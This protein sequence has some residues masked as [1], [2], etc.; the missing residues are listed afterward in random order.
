MIP[1]LIDQLPLPP[2]C[3]ELPENVYRMS[4]PVDLMLR[5]GRL[6]KGYLLAFSAK[7]ARVLLHTDA[8]TPTDARYVLFKDIALLTVPQA[9][10]VVRAS[11]ALANRGK[12]VVPPAKQEFEVYVRGGS[13]IEGK[14]FSFRMDRHGLYLFPAKGADNFSLL[15]AAYEA[16]EK[17]RIGPLLGKALISDKAATAAVIDAGLAEQKRKREQ[18]LG[19]YLQAALVVSAEQLNEVLKRQ[20]S[21]PGVRLGEMLLRENMVSE[22][23]LREALSTQENDRKAP[24]G[25]FL[26]SM[27]LV[28]EEALGRTLAKKLGVP[29]VD[30]RNFT[31]DLNLLQLIPEDIVRKH[32]V[33]PLYINDGRLLVFAVNDPTKWESTHAI[34]FCCGLLVEPVMAMKSDIAWAIDTYYTKQRNDAMV[35]AGV[36]GDLFGDQKIDK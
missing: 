8:A 9:R 21:M 15:F 13:R 18:P 3:V 35:A 34:Q 24:I 23:E 22:R 27:G 16:V 1:K 26:V 29:F 6:Q 14:T 36:L 7:E 30:L 33:M 11:Q 28:S 17:H 31:V 2:L 4:E 25:E 5:D 20:K 10:K 19:E 32:Q 12:I